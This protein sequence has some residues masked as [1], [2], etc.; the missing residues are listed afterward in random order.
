MYLRGSL[1]SFKVEFGENGGQDRLA[2]QEGQL[3]NHLRPRTISK[4]EQNKPGTMEY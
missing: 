4:G 3:F 2:N 1:A